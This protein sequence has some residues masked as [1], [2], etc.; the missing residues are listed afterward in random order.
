MRG[1]T[2]EA[3]GSNGVGPASTFALVER[4]RPDRRDAQGAQCPSLFEE[5]AS[6]RRAVLT[7]Y[8]SRPEVRR[9][10]RGPRVGRPTSGESCGAHS[11]ARRRGGVP[12][13]GLL[14]AL[15][16]VV[17]LGAGSASASPAVTRWR[18]E[19]DGTDGE[20][21][22]MKG[23]GGNATEPL[24]HSAVQRYDSVVAM[25]GETVTIW[26]GI[27]LKGTIRFQIANTS[28][29]NRATLF[30][31]LY[32]PGRTKHLGVRTGAGAE[33]LSRLAVGH[34]LRATDFDSRTVILVTEDAQVAA[35]FPRIRF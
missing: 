19:S 25:P 12:R 29:T 15:A 34:K 4:G 26:W 1:V 23:R 2:Q 22:A 17:A 9:V 10:V 33:S 13:T 7:S 32:P 5:H 3:Q 31:V 16:T 20:R 21:R 8:S 24:G 6:S 30:W 35:S 11:L 27:N 28:G 14:L 18:S